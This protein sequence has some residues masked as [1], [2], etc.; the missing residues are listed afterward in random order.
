MSEISEKQPE[1]Q[2]THFIIETPPLEGL[3]KLSFM[4]QKIQDPPEEEYFSGFGTHRPFSA[5]DMKL[6]LEMKTIIALPVP[7]KIERG[8]GLWM[9]SEKNVFLA[10][11]LDPLSFERKKVFDAK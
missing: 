2:V 6:K 11:I 1:F 8:Q 9:D 3:K 10:H 7:E 4:T 5:S